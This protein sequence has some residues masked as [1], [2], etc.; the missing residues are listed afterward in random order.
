MLARQMFLFA[1]V[2]PR[3]GAQSEPIRGVLRGMLLFRH[4]G[5]Y[6]LHPELLFNCFN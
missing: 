5:L 4:R 1:W 3:R 2:E 6:M